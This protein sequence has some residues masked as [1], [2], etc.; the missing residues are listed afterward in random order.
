MKKDRVVYTV[1]Q[2]GNFEKIAAS[3]IKPRL[4]YHKKF[5]DFSYL[6]IGYYLLTPI[7]GGVFL[8]LGLDYWLGVKPVFFFV[9]LFLG[10]LASFY[11]I[12]KLLKER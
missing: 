8:G 12:F 5:I 10:T 6:N 9:F 7:I 1:D 11:N 3:K 2:E 4:D